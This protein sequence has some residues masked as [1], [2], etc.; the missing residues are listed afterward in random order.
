VTEPVR[1]EDLRVSDAER[2]V[3]QQRLHQAH[4]AGQIDL[5]EF[6]ERLQEVLKARTRG[7]LQRTTADLPEVPPTAAPARKA[8]RA[9][10]F[11]DTGGGTTM[12]VLTIIWASIVA[13][14][15]VVWGI[16]SITN[17]ELI[18]PW[19]LWVAGPPGAVLA[20]LYAAGIGRPRT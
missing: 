13:V 7:E 10:V 2:R 16:V 3:V 9:P 18:Y 20:V 17:V 4:D 8:G 14:N 12:R 6:D 1:P 5:T 11:S 19:F 15:L